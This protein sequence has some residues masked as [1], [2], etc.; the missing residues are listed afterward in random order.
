M[1][2][3][4]HRPD[5]CMAQRVHPSTTHYY[6]SCKLPAGHDGPHVPDTEGPPN[7]PSL[8]QWTDEHTWACRDSAGKPINWR[9][10]VEAEKVERYGSESTPP[11]IH[12]S[13]ESI[14]ELLAR[15]LSKSHA[16]LS[17][18]G[19]ISTLRAEVE[20]LRELEF[21]MNKH[22][23]IQDRFCPSCE[24]YKATIGDE[25]IECGSDT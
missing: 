5:P 23:Y 6:W 16:A 19:E 14:E 15:N 24:K 12:R 21:L 20:R 9:A 10:R 3:P 2:D 4:E 1:A 18:E 25:C 11:E 8:Q 22:G 17:G 7:H 13:A